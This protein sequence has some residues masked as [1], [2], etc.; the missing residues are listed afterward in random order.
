[1]VNDSCQWCQ[2]YVCK[3]PALFTPGDPTVSTPKAEAPAEKTRQQA[4]LVTDPE[5]QALADILAEFTP[6]DAT[7]IIR[8][9]SEKTWHRL[10]AAKP[11]QGT[12]RPSGRDFPGPSPENAS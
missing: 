5:I 10:E 6:A 7:R 11:P 2:S 9:L 8:Y 4:K 12:V 3:C 1:V